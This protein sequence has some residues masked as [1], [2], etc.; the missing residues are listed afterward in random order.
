[1]PLYSNVFVLNKVNCLAS[2]GSLYCRDDHFNWCSWSVHS[3]RKH[4]ALFSESDTPRRVFAGHVKIRI[5]FAQISLQFRFISSRSEC[6]KIITTGSKRLKVPSKLTT[7][8]R[9]FN[10]YIPKE[11]ITFLS[12]GSIAMHCP[13]PREHLQ[14]TMNYRSSI[15]VESR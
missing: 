11:I 3:H 10:E 4:K 9:A 1:M 8:S 13:I 2:Y 14:G 6:R 5:S 12:D 15:T 7:H